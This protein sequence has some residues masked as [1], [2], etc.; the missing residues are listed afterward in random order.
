MI[1]DFYTSVHDKWC[2]DWPN[3]QVKVGGG[4]SLAQF[5]KD[6]I[7]HDGIT[8]FRKEF[9]LREQVEIEGYVV[10]LF[11]RKAVC[12]SNIVEDA[13]LISPSV[14]ESAYMIGP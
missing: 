9:G 11:S 3:A 7:F 14:L 8:A 10:L 2:S 5:A 12:I 4:R 13:V 6:M 1:F